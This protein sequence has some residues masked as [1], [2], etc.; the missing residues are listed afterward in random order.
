MYNMIKADTYRILRSKGLYIA[1]FMIILMLGLS[2]FMKEPGFIGTANVNANEETAETVETLE[3]LDTTNLGSIIEAFE[4]K[5]DDAQKKRFVRELLGANINMYYIL[6]MVVFMVLVADFSNQTIKNTLT[7]AVSKRK[8]FASKLVMILIM[9]TILMFFNTFFAYGLNY[10]V[11][12][13]EYTESIIEP[14]KVTVLQLPL[15]YGMAGILTF[16]AFLI[17]KPA[18]FNSVTICLIMIFQLLMAAAQYIT[19]SD[20]LDTFLRKYEFQ[21]ALSYI[22][23]LSDTQHALIC[24]SAG[25][26]ILVYSVIGGYLIFKK[27]EI[28]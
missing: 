20:S 2:I 24:A 3:N 7:S 27:A 11:N 22:S 23:K 28:K 14:L 26:Q 4:S 25:F 19:K 15:M 21:S 5:R 16:I 1:L 10:I 12:G 6:I 13:S 9:T 17:N 18:I 8:Y